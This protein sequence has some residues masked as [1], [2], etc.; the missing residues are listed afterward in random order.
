MLAILCSLRPVLLL[1]DNTFPQEPIHSHLT[2]IDSKIGA[3]PTLSNNFSQIAK[4]CCI[5]VE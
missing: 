4:K 1:L 5:L 3:L 2:Y